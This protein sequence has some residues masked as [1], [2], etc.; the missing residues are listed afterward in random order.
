MRRWLI[1]VSAATTATL[2]TPAPAFAD[3]PSVAFLVFFG[4]VNFLAVQLWI[5]A[6]EFTYLA[7]LLKGISKTVV[8]WWT[9]L[10][11]VASSIVGIIPF[12]A[13]YFLLALGNVSNSFAYDVAFLAI[14]Y[15]ISVVVEGWLLYHLSKRRSDM[16]IRYLMKHSWGFNAVSYVGLLAV[17]IWFALAMHS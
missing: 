9:I 17:L 14:T 8:L 13:F 3:G 12:T 10:I 4:F 7:C 15:P 5:V 11:N 2:L 6:S 16:S 1:G